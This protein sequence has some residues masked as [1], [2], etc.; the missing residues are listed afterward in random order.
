MRARSSKS[1]KDP[2]KLKNSWPRIGILGGGQLARMLV[3]ASH[4]L[5]MDVRVFCESDTEPAPQVTP[6]FYIGSIK[7]K[8][9]K[10][11]LSFF[12]KVD[13][14]TFESEFVSVEVIEDLLKENPSLASRLNFFPKLAVMREL[15][16]R[17]SQK[18]F[19]RDHKLP[20]SE[21][22]EPLVLEAKGPWTPLVLKKRQGGYD[23]YGTFIFKQRASLE[24]WM[25]KQL[26][27][28]S[29]SRRDFIQKNFIVEKWIPFC[30]ELAFSMARDRSG[31]TV[32]LPLVE[33][34]QLQSRCDWVCGPV[35]HPRFRS[36]ERKIKSAL[37]DLDYVGIIAFEL[38]DTGKDLLINE[39]APR[40]HNSAH[41]SQESM[42][43]S[44]FDLHLLCS[45]EHG[46]PSESRLR[47]SFAMLNLLGTCPTQIPAARAQL[48][49]KLHWYG[50]TE[51]RPGRK[52][53]HINYISQSKI[54]IKSLLKERQLHLP[55]Q[56]E[57]PSES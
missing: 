53:G 1:N 48:T 20:T 52:M 7:D 34:H 17:K 8:S 22:L 15:Q 21:D 41:H 46:L 3:E 54:N 5:G 56:M 35:Q 23:G 40:V 33:T 25:A 42:V 57:K 50:K 44:Q 38:F 28:V 14:V 13:L 12:E 36:L 26:R 19:L 30:R 45:T 39:V 55:H 51:A 49:G 29:L 31:Q 37:E 2:L 10:D 6:R 24:K 18:Q 32:T 4:E 27:D 47:G 11:L 43:L 16:D 9:N